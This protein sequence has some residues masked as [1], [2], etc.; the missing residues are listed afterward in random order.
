[1]DLRKRALSKGRWII[2][3]LALAL[4][5]FEAQSAEGRRVALVIG[6]SEYAFADDLRN[7]GQD[8]SA[9]GETLRSLHFDVVVR[10][11]IG[12][13]AFAAALLDFYRMADGAD[14]ALFF[15]SGHGFQ[16]GGSNRIVPADARL[17]DEASLDTETLPLDEIA[18]ELRRRSRHSLI[19]LD[20]CRNDP[21]PAGFKSTNGGLAPVDASRLTPMDTA[22]GTF[23]A[24]A[25][26][27]GNV[28]TDGEGDHS[29]FTAALLE[30]LPTRGIS[31][32]DMMIRVRNGVRDAT[33]ERQTPWDQS[34]LHAQFYFN[35]D[36]AQI[37][38]EAAS[39]AQ[40]TERDDAPQV[41][42]RLII[43]P[44]GVERGQLA[45]SF[46]SEEP[47]ARRAA[48]PTPSLRLE[49]GEDV[50]ADREEAPRIASREAE[51][52]EQT[53]ERIADS[54]NPADFRQY[55][56]AYPEGAFARIARLN[57]KALATLDEARKRLEELQL[58]Q[59]A[60]QGTELSLEELYWATIR[61]STLADDFHAYLRAFPDGDF[62]DLASARIE[63]LERA[64]EVSS[65]LAPDGAAKSRAAMRAAA[66]QRI[67][68]VPT[69]FIQ[70]GLIALGYPLSSVSGVIDAET[71]RSARA[72]QASLSAEQTG[73]L[74]AQQTVELLLAAASVG[75]EHA[76]TAVGI[77]MAA[78][79]GLQ[80]DYG[81]A[82]LW[83]RH[84]AEKGN[85]YA[86]TNLAI[87]YRDGLG[88]EKDLAAAEDLFEKAADGG[89]TE[90]ADALKELRG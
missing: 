26:E 38:E 9:I 69:Q 77:M 5:P 54:T 8:A 83:L 28:S 60:A 16:L 90:A 25:T 85:T 40:Q 55:L 20:A 31:I 35:P 36:E 22:G 71:R 3:A 70:Y 53:W 27:P 33:E 18:L 65:G 56:D 32:T 68:R 44:A 1:M 57:L 17:V 12:R 64:A 34:S 82:R 39:R 37:L 29:P 46:R 52:D 2:L 23:V 24:F 58:A 15:Y 63:A 86:Q 43:L 47:S 62:G 74:T 19:F 78:G 72:Y 14:A 48:P 84:A 4:L 87:L 89:L 51:S 75:D 45:R 76:Q 80:Q 49:P 21:R 11:D 88:G 6:I 79:Q 81:L 10:R 7:A 67:D 30:H 41:A 59:Q 66:M 61:E 50:Q 42:A 73:Q 13:D